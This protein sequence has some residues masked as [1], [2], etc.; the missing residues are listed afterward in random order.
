MTVSMLTCRRANGERPSKLTSSSFLLPNLLHTCAL[1]S[2][3]LFESISFIT[4]DAQHDHKAGQLA[5]NVLL[6]VSLRF[7]YLNRSNQG[8]RYA[9]TLVD[10]AGKT[11][12][13]FLCLA[14]TLDLK[15]QG[16]QYH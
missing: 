3:I 16:T 6:I 8:I 10:R 4:K 14:S 2:K 7:I 15:L 13:W 5:R 12:N 1:A 9:E 11:H